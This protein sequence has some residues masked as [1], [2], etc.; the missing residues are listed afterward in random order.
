MKM[1]PETVQVSMAHPY[2]GT[3]FY[4]YLENQGY[5]ISSDMTDEEGHQLPSFEYPD[6]SKAEI[7]KAVED[8]YGRYYFRPRVIFRI[9]RGAFFDATDRRRLYRG[10]KEFLKLRSKRKDFIHS[11]NQS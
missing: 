7:L 3:E 9:I 11:A 6:L 2:P 10:G 1:D 5:L 8:L 4:Q